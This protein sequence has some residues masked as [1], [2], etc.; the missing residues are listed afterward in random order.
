[1]REL[2]QYIPSCGT[3]RNVKVALESIAGWAILT[4]QKGLK[5]M[6]IELAVS[7]LEMRSEEVSQSTLDGE[8]QALELML[9]KCTKKLGVNEK[10]PLV[11]SQ[12]ET[13]LNCRAY[14]KVQAIGIAS[15]QKPKNALATLISLDAGVRAHELF[16]LR[17][18][19]EATL[20]DRDFRVDIFLNRSSST[21]SLYAVDG[22]GGLTRAVS[23]KNELVK[24][25][26]LRRLLSP[27]KVV[28]R[29]INYTCL[30]DIGGGENWSSSFSQ[31]SQKVCGFTNGAHGLRHSYAQ[32]RM[33]LLQQVPALSLDDCL[34]IVSQELGHFRPEIT[35][36]YLRSK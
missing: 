30:Y 17:P 24:E 11:K 15:R 18:I 20:S 2:S 19:A 36:V 6:S 23:I 35:W 10:L 28:D 26:E 32:K 25:L 3:N 4:R 9:Q 7:F 1:M 14:S 12:L 34:E 27:K 8:R 5:D 31:M 22:K 16:T 33:I 29:G 13:I 21:H